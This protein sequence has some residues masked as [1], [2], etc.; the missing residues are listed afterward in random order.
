MMNR[1]LTP[2]Q[3]ETIRRNFEFSDAARENMQ[4]LIDEHEERRRLVAERRAR[5]RRWLPFLGRAA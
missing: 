4:R 2:E 1:K 5:R 3:R